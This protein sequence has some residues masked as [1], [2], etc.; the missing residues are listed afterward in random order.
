MVADAK[1]TSLV[2]WMHEDQVGR[3]VCSLEPNC[4]SGGLGE[5]KVLEVGG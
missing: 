3:E 4:A 2:A 1:L 5:R